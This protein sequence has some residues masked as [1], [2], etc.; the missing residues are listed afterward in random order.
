MGDNILKYQ[1]SQ[2]MWAII[3]RGGTFK[4]KASYIK[5]LK[6]LINYGIARNK[7]WMK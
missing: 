1:K 2:D 7:K 6:H 5:I 4:F 3:N